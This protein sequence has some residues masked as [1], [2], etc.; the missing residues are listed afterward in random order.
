MGAWGP[1]IFSNDTAAD[2]RDEW[3]DALIEGEEPRAISE[4]LVERLGGDSDDTDF[5]TGLAAAQFETGHLQEDVRDR[6]LALIAAG[7]DLELWEDGEY[8]ARKRALERLAEKLRGPQPAP[9]RLRG[10]RPGPDPGVDAGDVLR[11]WSGDRRRCALFVV[12]AMIPV[13]RSR[14][15]FVVGL[16]TEEDPH[17]V[18]PPDE[19]ARLPY[20]SCGT[21]GDDGELLEWAL[22][23]APLAFG[24]MVS[25]AGDEFRPEI[26]AVVARGVAAPP[27]PP[28]LDDATDLGSFAT[29][30]G[31]VEA[32]DLHREATRRRLDG[33]GAAARAE[34]ERRG[35]AVQELWASFLASAEENEDES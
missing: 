15:P 27:L 25:R 29:L 17:D 16:Y 21:P 9:K 11:V 22:V 33:R 2:A 19:L 5:W 8:A 1:G 4:R 34:F 12:A 7:G 35:E 18:P 31:E 20:L 26:G 23:D 28:G 3:R 24:C 6:T 14:W 10:P 32:I 30:V 13:K